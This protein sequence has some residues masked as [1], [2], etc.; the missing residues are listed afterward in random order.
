M[1]GQCSCNSPKNNDA[2]SSCRLSLNPRRSWK[3]LRDCSDGCGRGELR[4]RPAAAGLG[5]SRRSTTSLIDSRTILSHFAISRRK[6]GTFSHRSGGTTGPE[7][8]AT[9]QKSAVCFQSATMNHDK[10]TVIRRR[11]GRQMPNPSQHGR[12]TT[13]HSNAPMLTHWQLFIYLVEAVTRRRSD[14]ALST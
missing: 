6:P 5:R 1:A 14:R 2:E 9:H 8:P 3:I 13:Q 10:A 4:E 11:T 7:I 12:K